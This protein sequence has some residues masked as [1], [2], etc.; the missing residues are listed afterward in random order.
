MRILVEAQCLRDF[1]VITVP[2]FS[3]SGA[4]PTRVK[5]VPIVET[6]ANDILECATSPTTF[7]RNT[8]AMI[9]KESW[10]RKRSW[11]ATSN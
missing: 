2:A 6:S 4:L 5:V 9:L 3:M 11:L 10:P 7:F 1:A 8:K